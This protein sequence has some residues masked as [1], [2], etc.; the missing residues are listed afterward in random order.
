MGWHQIGWKETI[1]WSDVE[2]TQPRSWFGRTNN[3]PGSCIHGLHSKK[4]RN[5]QRYCEQ[6]QDHVWISNFR[7]ENKLPY[8][9]NFR[10][11]SW[12]FDLEGHVKKC[13]ERY[14]ELQ[15]RRLNNS[16]KYPLHASMTIISNRK[17]WNLLEKLSHVSSQIVLKCLHLARIGRPDIL[18]SVNKLARSV[19]KWTKA[20][21]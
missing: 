13:V 4:M 21:D 6:S 5:K 17:N 7:G 12:S 14:C 1:H 20:C 10:I 19:T 9:E 18:W 11:S 15:T 2:S 8:S 16:L 3:F